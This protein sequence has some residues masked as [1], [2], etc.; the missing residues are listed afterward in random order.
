MIGN[1]TQV[2][3]LYENAEFTL[4]A[5]TNYNAALQ[6]LFVTC[7]NPKYVSIRTDTS[8]TVRFNSATAPA[9]TV[10][11][12]TVLELYFQCKAIYITTSGSTAIKILLLS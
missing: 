4:G 2:P 9:I 3:T 5:Q 10:A 11:A 12:N 1:Y 6:A 7:P 8:M